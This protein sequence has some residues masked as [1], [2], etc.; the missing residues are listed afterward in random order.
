MSEEPYH[1]PFATDSP[2]TAVLLSTPS[3][4]LLNESELRERLRN[5]RYKIEERDQSACHL[6]FIVFLFKCCGALEPSH[7]LSTFMLFLPDLVFAAEI[8]QKLLLDNKI[9]RI[10]NETL[11]TQQSQANGERTMEISAAIAAAAT[12]SSNE[13]HNVLA[14]YTS[15]LERVNA[16]LQRELDSATQKL[17]ES[18]KASDKQLQILRQELEITKRGLDSALK[19]N[20]ELEDEKKRLAREKAGLAR[21]VTERRNDTEMLEQAQTRVYELEATVRELMETKRE[22]EGRYAAAVEEAAAAREQC[23]GY[24]GRLVDMQELRDENEARAVEISELSLAVEEVNEHA[25]AL[26]ARLALL[27]PESAL[28]PTREGVTLFSEVED[29]RLELE[30]RNRNL[31]IRHAGLAQAHTA[32]VH[33]QERMKHHISRL[34]Q[35]SQNAG[36]EARIRRLE[37]ALSQSRGENRLLQTKLVHLQKSQEAGDGIGTRVPGSGI[38]YGPDEKDEVIETLR[39][40]VEQLDE[41][42]DALRKELRTSQMV[43]LSES[44]K[45]RQAEA[46]LAERETEFERLKTANAQIK[47]ELDEERLMVRMKSLAEGVDDAAQAEAEGT[48]NKRG[49]LVSKTVNTDKPERPTTIHS[50]QQTDVVSVMSQEVQTEEVFWPEDA[51]VGSILLDST[52]VFTQSR[53]E[54]DDNDI[55]NNLGPSAEIEMNNSDV[56]FFLSGRSSGS[57]MGGSTDTDRD[58]ISHEHVLVDE[59]NSEEESSWTEGNAT[60]LSNVLGNLAGSDATGQSHPSN[61]TSPSFPSL[62]E[63]STGRKHAHQ[64]NEEYE[65]QGERSPKDESSDTDILPSSLTAPSPCSRAGTRGSPHIKKLRRMA[66]HKRPHQEEEEEEEEE[67][68]NGEED[69][70]ED[71]TSETDILPPSLTAPSPSFRTGKRGSPHPKK[72]RMKSPLVAGSA[73]AGPLRPLPL[74]RVQNEVWEQGR[75]SGT[76]EKPKQLYVKRQN[77]RPNECHQQ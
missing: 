53:Y 22:L 56:K 20:D 50:V 32:S 43:W 11:R 58:T 59:N 57:T 47:F 30:D 29:K 17:R 65:E 46:L 34:T 71:E 66:G 14:A 41:D 13:R 5:V 67:E 42:A 39:L 55:E 21:T 64:N 2:P 73:E 26:E 48:R 44:E 25:Q 19:R 1:S 31:K 23:T 27:E 72:L 16:D 10:E 38:Y 8:G 9:L 74:D 24:E 18:D 68:G 52:H 51:V 54:D 33:Q 28:G 69:V 49:N 75:R 37:E 36:Q 63:P 7:L 4:E 62:V 12:A 3:L 61:Q 40:R 70:S 45:V 6:R 76:A 15:D 77:V 35:L 60:I